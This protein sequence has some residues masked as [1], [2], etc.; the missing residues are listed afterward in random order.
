MGARHLYYILT[1]QRRLL[2]EWEVLQQNDAL[3]QFFN[4]EDQL[5]TFPQSFLQ[6]VQAKN[7]STYENRFWL[8][9]PRHFPL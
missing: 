9:S 1:K 4:L 7:E 8:R 2:C 6:I 5:S 3:C